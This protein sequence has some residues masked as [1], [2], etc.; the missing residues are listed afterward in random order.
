MSQ[1][2][3]EN[4]IAETLAELRSSNVPPEMWPMVLAA[5]LEARIPLK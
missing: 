5:I 4:L 3:L 1:D 2:P